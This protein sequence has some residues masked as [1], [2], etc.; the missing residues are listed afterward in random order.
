MSATERRFSCECC[1]KSEAAHDA[2]IAATEREMFAY[3]GLSK[4]DT[5]S[6]RLL[7]LEAW[8]PFVKREVA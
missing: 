8:R 6:E 2:A 4:D 1:C 7:K 5:K 3:F